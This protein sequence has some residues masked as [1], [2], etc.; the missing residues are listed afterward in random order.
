MK[1]ITTLMLAMALVLGSVS[2]AK[3]D[4]IDIKVKGQWD[5][6]FGWADNMNFRESYMP[7]NG[8]TNRSKATKGT[9]GDNFL[10]RHRIRTQV[11]FIS[12]EY[13]QGVVMFEIGDINWG[14]NKNGS[15]GKSSGGQLDTDGVNIE[16]KLAYLDWVIP[17][18]E[19]AIRM[20]L[21]TLT[22]P[23]TPMG[24]PL[25]D[26]DV[27]GIVASAPI[28]D[29]LSAALFWIRPFDADY[30]DGYQSS[31]G[32]DLS[33]ETDAF[34]IL[35]PMTFDGVKFTPYFIW[36]RVGTASG[37]YGYLYDKDGLTL[38]SADESDHSQVWWLG[39]HLE[40]S[41]FDPLVFNIEGI[42]GNLSRANVNMDAAWNDR[43]L[44]ARVGD[45]FDADVKTSGWIIAATLDYKLDFMTPG[46]FG[47]YASGDDDDAW[48]DGEFGRMPVLGN[49][50]GSFGPTSFGSAGYYGINQQSNSGTI[51]GTG[52]GTWGIGLQLA[53]I[54]FIEDL[55]HTIRVA[56]YRGTNDADLLKNSNRNPAGIYAQYNADRFY[57]TDKDYVWEVNFDHQYKIY[58]NLTAVLELGWLRMHA[59]KDTW[60]NVGNTNGL[61]ENDNAW[62]AQLAFRYKF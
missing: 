42:Y 5:F 20:G 19:I 44:S 28:T 51:I 39:G 59:D 21:Q 22:L 13:L 36:G 27:A 14:Q 34:G 61:K 62:K 4:G 15:T 57:L 11:N 47:W 41:L 3:A 12:S 56:Y 31:T 38:R 8:F 17:N 32:R 26:A 50:G 46:I 7:Q 23:S 35:L 37:L 25:F 30:N 48:E 9:K 6:S 49:D 54:S 1:R 52:M 10:A 60:A 43:G 53:D 55:S 29:W 33:D 40:L 18:T 24:S 16:T 2:I 58:E 45:R